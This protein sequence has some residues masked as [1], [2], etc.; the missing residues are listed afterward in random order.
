MMQTKSKFKM[1]IFTLMLQLV[2]GTSAQAAPQS[3][4]GTEDNI[5]DISPIKSPSV[6]SFSYS[7]EGVFSIS[8]VDGTGKE[9]LPYQLDIGDAE[10]TYFQETPKKPI[11][12]LAVKG[13]GSWTVTVDSLKSV[14][15]LGSKSGSGSASTVISLGK[16]TTGVKRITW[17]HN[18]EGVFSVTPIDSKGRSK[19]PLFL[20][21]GTYSGTV[22][23]PSGTTYLA[24]KAD[25]DWK[26]SIK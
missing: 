6:I 24:I 20:K 1:V 26:Y 9:G 4:T 18:G 14:K 21:I 16:A 11:V 13:S 2:F 10:G 5:V 7:G 19:F 23:L 12:A 8:P 15:V 25:G 3:F 17:N 22:S